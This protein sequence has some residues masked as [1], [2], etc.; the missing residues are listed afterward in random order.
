M[1][2]MGE[3]YSPNL[4]FCKGCGI[5]AKECPRNAISMLPEGRI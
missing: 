5:C 3:Y 4:E 2:D 1:I